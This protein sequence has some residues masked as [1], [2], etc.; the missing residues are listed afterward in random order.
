M[1]AKL[2]YYFSV[3]WSRNHSNMLNWCSK[4]KIN[5]Y[6][7][8]QLIWWTDRLEEQNLLDKNLN[9][10]YVFFNQFNVSLLNKSIHLKKS[11]WSQIVEY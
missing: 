10:I 7:F 1:V 6:I 2:N 5:K 11:H 9:M 3:P 4:W 8:L